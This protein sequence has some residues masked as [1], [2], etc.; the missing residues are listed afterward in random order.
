MFWLNWMWTSY[1]L[2]FMVIITDIFNLVHLVSHRLPH[3][4]LDINGGLGGGWEVSRGIADI[5]LLSYQAVV[6]R[7]CCILL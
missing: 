3:A 7:V 1:V 6:F 4:G 5:Y 2:M